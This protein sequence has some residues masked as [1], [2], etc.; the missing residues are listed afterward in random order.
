M[1]RLLTPRVQQATTGPL[2]WTIKAA[3]DF[4]LN[5][6]SLIFAS[7]PDSTPRI[8]I[9][10]R[11]GDDSSFDFIMRKIDP[12]MYGLHIYLDDF[13]GEIRNGNHVE[14]VWLNSNNVEVRG[15]ATVQL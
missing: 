8:E 5:S 9:W 1:S 7:V 12:A 3:D 6:I 13:V 14:V 4:K 2:A 11:N 10:Q 15:E